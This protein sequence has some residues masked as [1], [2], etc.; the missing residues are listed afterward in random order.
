[1]PAPS[2]PAPAVTP[3]PAEVGAAAP[4]SAPAVA[5]LAGL[6]AAANG[7]RT[8]DIAAPGAAPVET[9]ALTAMPAGAHGPATPTEPSTLP[10]VIPGSSPCPGHLSILLRP[11]PRQDSSPRAASSSTRALAPERISATP[12]DPQATE[13]PDGDDAGVGGR[14]GQGPAPGHARRRGRKRRRT[15]EAP[16]GRADGM[17]INA[18]AW[19][20]RRPGQ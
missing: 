4:A 9:P 12:G 1:M 13:G 10:R 8:W 18:P 3:G 15:D 7:P 6:A 16:A 20:E 14:R 2:P 11:T 5:D 19:H 17:A